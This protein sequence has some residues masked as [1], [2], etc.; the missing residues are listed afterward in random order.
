MNKENTKLFG[1][2]AVNAGLSFRALEET[3]QNT[4]KWFYKY[5]SSGSDLAVGMK[6]EEMR[7]LANR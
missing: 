6:P 3:V 7:K 1:S 2:K 5:K 4:L